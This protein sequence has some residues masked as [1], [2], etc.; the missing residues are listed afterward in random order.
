MKFLLGDSNK[1]SDLIK[2]NEI[3]TKFDLITFAQ[4]FHWMEMESVLKQ[5]KEN[6]LA[7]D[8]VMAVIGYL[9][10]GFELDCEDENLRKMPNE[11][12]LKFCGPVLKESVFD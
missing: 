3:S 7:K 9:I 4:C 6:L 10:G 12:Y 8:G 1:L 5:V 2:S 11:G